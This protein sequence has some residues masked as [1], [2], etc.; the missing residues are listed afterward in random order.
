MNATANVKPVMADADKAVMMKDIHA[1]WDKITESEGLALK[2]KEDLV[3][4]VAAKYGYGQDRAKAN[5]E[6]DAVLK[7][8]AI[9]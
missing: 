6:V 1:K 7:G 8:R 4:M 9:G 2:S 3:T 5:A